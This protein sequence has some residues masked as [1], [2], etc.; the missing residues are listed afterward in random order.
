MS[1]KVKLDIFE[2]PFDLLVYL[3]EHARMDIYDIKVSEITTQY[4][5]YIKGLQQQDVEVAQEFMVLAAELIEL[6]SKMLLPRTQPL[7]DNGEVPED[8]RAGLVARILEY[9]Q[10]K[11][12][13][14]FLADQEEI[15]SHV[16][17]KP[18]ED[19]AAY[20]GEEDVLLKT[21]MESFVKAFSLFISRKQ[22]VEEVR[23]IYERVERQRMS[24]ETRMEQI[25]GVLAAKK[26]ILFTD[27][28]KED[29]SAYNQ[30]ITFISLLEMLRQG[31]ISAYQ[32]E[33]Y[34]NIQIK[35]IANNSGE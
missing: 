10:F 32:K 14:E 29:N 16:H 3:I 30:V 15:T 7:E 11:N 1:Y 5:E 20:T 22:R 6:K 24:V 26:D 28:L 2:G 27:L 31:I 25:A 8:P 12:M 19:L 17:V 21:D 9:K 33:R 18:Q 13:A 4:L 23:R 34:A 35:L